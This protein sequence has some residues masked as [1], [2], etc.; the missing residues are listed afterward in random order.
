MSRTRRPA[1]KGHCVLCARTDGRIKGL[2]WSARM[3][4]Q[5]MR[6][7]GRARRARRKHVPQD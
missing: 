5:E 3:R 6:L 4:R 2:G 1:Y 7:V